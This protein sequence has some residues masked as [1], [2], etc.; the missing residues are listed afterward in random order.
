MEDLEN[1]R[2]PFKSI[3]LDRAYLRPLGTPLS[4]ISH[5]CAISPDA[6]R[7]EQ[8]LA[9]AYR[10]IHHVKPG[11]IKKFA[12]DHWEVSVYEDISTYDYDVLT[13]LVLA[14]HKYAVRV[15][16]KSSGPRLLKLTLFARKRDAGMTERHPTIQQ[17]IDKY[18]GK[19]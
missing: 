3:P 5:D 10:G 4:E 15:S 8:V 2:A 7:I 12:D 13:R 9:D 1:D 11:E 17:A 19:R 6:T 14:A 18:E 16:I